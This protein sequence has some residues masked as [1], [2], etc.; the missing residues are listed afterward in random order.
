MPGAQ[1][2]VGRY[3]VVREIGR[4]GMAVVYLARQ[5]D[6][7]R[8]VALKE[9]ASFHALETGFAERFAREARVGGSLAHPSIVTV[10]EAFEHG[11]VPY[12]AMEYMPRGSLRPLVGRLALP[13]VAGVLEGLLAGLDHASARGV[14]HRDLKPEN[15]LVTGEGRVKIADFGIAKAFNRVWTAQ[16]RTAT[17]M[18]L[19]TPTYMAPEQA[20]GR[21]VSVRTDLYAVGVIAYEQ[22]A[23]RPPFHDVD[24]PMALLL[25]HVSEPV[26]SLAAAAPGVDPRLAE[27]VE[28]LLAK[29]PEARPAGAQ[30][31]WE[32]LEE[33]VVGLLGPLWR[34]DARLLAPAGG[35]ESRPLTPAPFEESAGY[36]TFGEAT[37]SITVPEP[38]PPAA[39]VPAEPATDVAAGE[40]DPPAGVG[41]EPDPPAHTPAAVGAGAEPGPPA[42]TPAA[43]GAES[44]PVVPTP[45]SVPEE[46]ATAM[47]AAPPRRRRR[48][49][50]AGGLAV[51]VAAAVAVVALSG[52]FGGGG[53]A[54][55]GAAVAARG[56][57]ACFTKLAADAIELPKGIEVPVGAAREQIGRTLTFLLESGAPIAAVSVSVHGGRAPFYRVQGFRD[58]RCRAVAAAVVGEPGNYPNLVDYNHVRATLAGRA[59]DFRLATEDKQLRALLSVPVDPRLAITAKRTASR[60]SVAGRLASDAYGDVTLTFRARR[61]DGTEFTRSATE[62]AHGGSFSVSARLSRAERK[63][64]AGTVTAVFEGDSNYLSARASTTLPAA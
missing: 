44:E 24:E 35:G 8:D 34:R 49:L 17:G 59:Y 62:T 13:Q 4:G 14:V 15:V 60:I 54:K 27:W 2:T 12:L 40:A 20:M 37:P 18:T 3:E 42:H 46:P 26:P 22:L 48:A 16:Y 63:L 21:E 56:L 64:Q 50:L 25:R 1:R 38:L 61:P 39:V 10:F 58:T 29:D 52:A 55:S 33:I 57:P 45:A 28:R 47:P 53:A 11:G 32:E 19:G 5:P 36:E 31:A 23:G 6:L 30:A 51:V 9:L 41:A 7:E 43:V